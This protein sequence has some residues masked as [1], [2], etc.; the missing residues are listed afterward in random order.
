MQ[1]LSLCVICLTDKPHANLFPNYSPFS[2][3]Y[4]FSLIQ[5]QS[6]LTSPKGYLAVSSSLCTE[7]TELHISFPTFFLDHCKQQQPPFSRLTHTL[8]LSKGC[9]QYVSK[10]SIAF[11]LTSLMSGLSYVKMSHS[12][13]FIQAFRILYLN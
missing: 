11:C 12:Y 2:L 6:Y 8:H 5:T 13:N 10:L 7:G 4:S 1:L 3:S 9:T